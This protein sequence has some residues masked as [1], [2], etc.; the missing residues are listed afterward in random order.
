MIQ[1]KN[2][3]QD[4]GLKPIMQ[5]ITLGTYAYAPWKGKDFQ[6]GSKSKTQLY[7]TL[8]YTL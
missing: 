5:I 4:N 3:Y 8:K 1:I 7:A 6:T 2:K